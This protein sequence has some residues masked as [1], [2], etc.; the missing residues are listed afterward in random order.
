MHQIARFNRYHLCINTLFM[1]VCQNFA[2]W[3]QQN[4]LHQNWT[5]FFTSASSTPWVQIR[6]K[7][8]KCDSDVNPKP[9]Q[10]TRTGW[11]TTQIEVIAVWGGEGGNV[12]F[13]WSEKINLFFLGNFTHFKMT[14]TTQILARIW[15]NH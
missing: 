6:V 9:R 4:I 3:P 11:G 1:G 7:Q 5:M 13:Q 8:W 14:F 15:E 12:I 10:C 2:S